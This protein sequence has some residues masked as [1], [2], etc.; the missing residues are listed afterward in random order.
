[1][2]IAIMSLAPW[3]P[4]STLYDIPLCAFS[5]SVRAN[6]SASKRTFLINR[7]REGFNPIVQC[8]DAFW[9]ERRVLCESDTPRLS[10]FSVRL[11]LRREVVRDVLILQDLLKRRVLLRTALKYSNLAL[12]VR[13]KQRLDGAPQVVEHRWRVQYIDLPWI[14]QDSCTMQRS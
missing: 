12:C 13:R 1:M 5:N 2:C 11:R 8:L 6:R 14:A 4:T 9:P 3:N 7:F 10:F